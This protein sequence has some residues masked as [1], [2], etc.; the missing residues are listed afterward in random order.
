V[1]QDS[2]RALAMKKA[3]IYSAPFVNGNYSKDLQLPE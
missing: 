3:P 1:A 2:T